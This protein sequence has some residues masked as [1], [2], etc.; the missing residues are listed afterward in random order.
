MKI[1]G[2]C[3][4]GD[5]RFEVDINC[6][7]DRSIRAYLCNCS[8]CEMTGFTHVIVS[9]VAFRLNAEEDRF[10][11]YKFRTKIARHLFCRQCGIKSFYIPR[12]NPDGFSINLNCLDLPSGIGISIEKIDGK[13]W[14]KNA[15]KLRHLSRPSG[16]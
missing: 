10:A 8:I 16:G 11:E 5:V 2:S 12:S 9:S 15:G 14:S 13:N 6:A 1:E 7:S 3:H 4:C